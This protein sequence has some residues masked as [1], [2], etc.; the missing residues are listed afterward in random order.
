MIKDNPTLA[1][2]IEQGNILK[3]KGVNLIQKMTMAESSILKVIDGFVCWR[4]A[5]K[6]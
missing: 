5:I 2:N 3:I 1:E 4:L 6:L